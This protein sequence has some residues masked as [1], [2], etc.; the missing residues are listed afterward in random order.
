MIVKSTTARAFVR[1][2]NLGLVSAS[3]I[4]TCFIQRYYTLRL[5]YFVESFLTLKL[6]VLGSHAAVGWMMMMMMMMMVMVMI[7]DFDPWTSH[8]QV[9]GGQKMPFRSGTSPVAR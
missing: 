2:Q 5:V 9:L 4:S 8:G 6:W 1:K 3:Y 7:D